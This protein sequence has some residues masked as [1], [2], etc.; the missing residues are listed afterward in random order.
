MRCRKCPDRAQVE[1]RRHN[2]AFCAPH[3]LEFFET[4]VKRNIKSQK[5]FGPDEKI[6]V[7]VSGGKDSLAL[8]DILIRLEYDVAGLYIDLGIGQYSERSKEKC[9]AFA[10]TVGGELHIKD[11]REEFGAGEVGIT[12]MSKALRRAPCSGCGLTKRYVM[13]DM[14]RSLG[15]SVLATGHNL[16]D[17]VATLLGN[18]LHWQTGYLARQSPVLESTHPKLARKVKPL[19][20]FAERET[21]SYVL[22]RGIDYIEEECPN[23]KG[24]KSLLYK[25]VLNKIEYESPG[26]KAAFM[27]GFLERARPLM[28]SEDTA[29]VRECDRCGEPTTGEVCSFCRTWDRAKAA[30]AGKKKPIAIIG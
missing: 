12:E 15:Y 30:W 10:K 27:N 6:L 7:A 1:M 18:V 20:T 13:N 24:A 25:D 21:L 14:A 17:E 22:L 5:M 3:Y 4:H 29:V 11:V 23:A 26:T 19:Y 2:T 16:D 8:W 9:Q 28:L